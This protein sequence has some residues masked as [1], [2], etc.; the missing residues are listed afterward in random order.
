M[1]VAFVLESRES[2]SN[3]GRTEEFFGLN[4]ITHCL[5]NIDLILIYWCVGVRD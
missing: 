3:S 4:I 2:S 5:T 1:K